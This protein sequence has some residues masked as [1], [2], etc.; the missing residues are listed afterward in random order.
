MLPLA[1]LDTKW[2]TADM[3][4]PFGWSVVCYTGHMRNVTFRQ[5]PW[6]FRIKNS[7]YLCA[8]YRLMNLMCIVTKQAPVLYN[9]TEKRSFLAITCAKLTE[10]Y[11]LV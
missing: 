10:K 9:Y 1:K 3:S 6:R 5:Y 4:N 8:T 11:V 7:A 2:K